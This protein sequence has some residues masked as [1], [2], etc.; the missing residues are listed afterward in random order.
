MEPQPPK[1][2]LSRLLECTAMLALSA[3]LIRLAVG[4]LLDV[5]PVLAIV[6]AM[7]AIALILYRLH[8]N[9]PHY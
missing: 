4:Y 8:K 7:A 6:A 1:K 3:F 9:R 2:L 5:W